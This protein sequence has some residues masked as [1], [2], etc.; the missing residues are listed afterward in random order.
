MLRNRRFVTLSAAFALGLFAQIGLFVH[1]IVRLS[2]TVGTGGAG[3]AVSAATV[4]AVVGRTI[5]AAWFGDHDRRAV[6]CSPSGPARSRCGRAACFSGSASA[7]S[8][9]CRRSCA[10]GV[11]PRRRWAGRGAGHCHQSGSIRL[12]A[13]FVRRIARGDRRLCG[14]ASAG[15]DTSNLRRVDYRRGTLSLVGFGVAS[16]KTCGEIRRRRASAPRKYTYCRRSVGACAQSL[17]THRNPAKRRSQEIPGES[18][19]LSRAAV[20]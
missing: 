7:I 10:V 9:R 14:A 3:A 11:R 6:A 15:R 12:C 19:S 16:V 2:P 20:A 1:L 8:P 18:P 4:C 13:G 17:P 5:V